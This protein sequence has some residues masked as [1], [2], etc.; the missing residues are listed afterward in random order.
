MPA[1]AAIGSFL[2]SAAGAETVAAAAVAAN[3]YST[4]QQANA[5]QQAADTQKQIAAETANQP[6]APT[7]SDTMN[8][9]QQNAKQIAQM[10]SYQS[11]VGNGNNTPFGSFDSLIQGQKKTL[12]GA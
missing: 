6:T 7:S 4:Q 11:T 10:A 2:G 12:L 5:A 9:Q 1:F 3:V 8:A